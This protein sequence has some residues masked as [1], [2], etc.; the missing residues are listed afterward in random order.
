MK[1]LHIFPNQNNALLTW[2]RES[3]DG[4][5]FIVAQ[6]VPL[7]EGVLNGRFVGAEE[8]GA[9]VPDWNDI[10]IVIRHPKQ[11][12]GSARV[13]DPDVP[14]V[15]RFYGAKLDGKRLVGE[16]WVEEDKLNNPD[17]E[18]ILARLAAQQPIETSTGYWA[19]SVPIAGSWNGRDFAFVDQNI[20]PDHIALLPDEIGACSLKDGCGM[21]RNAK[22]KGGPVSK[23]NCSSPHLQT[24]VD[25]SLEQRTG[26]VYDAF[27][28]AFGRN[29][30]AAAPAEIWPMS[31]FETHV[32]VKADGKFYQVNYSASGSEITFAPRDQWQEVLRVETYVPVQN[33]AGLTGTAANKK[34]QSE[35]LGIS[36]QEL[37]W[38][39]SL[40]AFVAS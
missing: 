6:S 18:I 28:A 16:Y 37:E 4:K 21:N 27:M 40:A 7:V 29:N 36:P 11:N 15:G 22:Q 31:T 32:I 13:L 14:I 12:G 19:E 25:G 10:P 34:K 20:H 3:R 38:L 39:A 17:G 30:E 2:R 5:D 9:F 35:S 1:S 26:L 23:C 8:F 33:V 24:N